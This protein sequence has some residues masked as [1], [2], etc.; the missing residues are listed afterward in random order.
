MWGSHTFTALGLT[1]G[2]TKTANVNWAATMTINPTSGPV[3]TVVTIDSGPGWV[4]NSTVHLKWK[5]AT[6]KDVVADASGKVHTT[7]AI[8]QSSSGT[9][10]LKLTD[11][12]LLKTA[13][14]DFTVTGLGPGQGMAGR[15][16]WL[17]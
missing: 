6:V 7:Y 15:L 8:P 14:A 4:P 12:V 3:G 1:S 17:R 13:S 9:F 2:I 11:D 5:N 10:Q 16:E